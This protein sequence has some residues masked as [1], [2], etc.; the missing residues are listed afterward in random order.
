MYGVYSEV[1]PDCQK[2]V[3]NNLFSQQ[4]MDVDQ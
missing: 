3:K 4:F 2:E 1:N